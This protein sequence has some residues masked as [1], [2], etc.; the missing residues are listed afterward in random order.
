MPDR[1]TRATL[2]STF[3]AAALIGASMGLSRTAHATPDER[4]PP[5]ALKS[6]WGTPGTGAGSF[7]EILSIAVDPTGRLYVVDI[8][9]KRLDVFSNVDGSFET[10]I[11]YPTTGG[12]AFTPEYVAIGPDGVS[13][14]YGATPTSYNIIK[15]YNADLTPAGADWNLDSWYSG[16]DLFYCYNMA[17][18]GDSFVWLIGY[19]AGVD[20]RGVLLK[21]GTDGTPQGWFR[22]SQ[23]GELTTVGDAGFA[24]DVQGTR[25]PSSGPAT[26][27]RT[28]SASTCCASSTRTGITCATGRSGQSRRCPVSPWT[29]P[30]SSTPLK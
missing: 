13:Y 25:M 21:V 20:T 15:R 22:M 24:G 5:L 2:R 12:S 4:L 17:I 3:L 6:T 18:A 14:V 28:I 16:I 27:P 8:G 23:G 29:K 1:E 26:I 11:Q 7:G 10:S 30:V 9:N 19:A